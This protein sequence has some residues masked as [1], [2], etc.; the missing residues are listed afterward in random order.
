M[1]T[2]QST[3][4]HLTDLLSDAGPIRALPMFGEFG[5]YCGIRLIGLVCDDRLYLKITDDTRD[6]G[7]EKA[8]PYPGAKPH[9][10]IDEEM[11]ENPET[12]LALVKV[13]YDALP[14]PKKVPKRLQGL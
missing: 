7:L 3:I 12:L 4:D 2:S 11:L 10:L 13:T 14:D 6:F 1:A 9:F 8:P 5:L